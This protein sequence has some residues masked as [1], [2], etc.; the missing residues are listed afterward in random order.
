MGENRE[1]GKSVALIKIIYFSCDVVFEGEVFHRADGDSVVEQFIKV[2]IFCWQCWRL[3]FLRV[4]AVI[5]PMLLVHLTLAKRPVV[6]HFRL[7][8]PKLSAHTVRVVLYRANVL[9]QLPSFVK[10]LFRVSLE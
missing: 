1:S 4:D 10:Y 6:G 9:D 8:V 7:V 3:N 5:D 2:V